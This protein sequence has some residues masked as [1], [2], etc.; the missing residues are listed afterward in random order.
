LIPLFNPRFSGQERF[1]AAIAG[2][3]D[4]DD[5]IDLLAIDRAPDSDFLGNMWRLL[6]EPGGLR[7]E[8]IGTNHRIAECPSAT[9]LCST[10]RYVVNAGL[11]IALDAYGMIATVDPTPDL[12]TCELLANHERCEPTSFTSRRLVSDPDPIVPHT[13]LAFDVGRDGSTEIVFAYASKT[14]L[15]SVLVCTTAFACDELVE[16][17]R[18]VDP[19]IVACVDAVPGTLARGSRDAGTVPDLVA[20]CRTASES[21]LFRID[22]LAASRVG[23]VAGPADAHTLLIDDVT[24]DAVDDIVLLRSTAEGPVVDV[25]RQRTLRQVGP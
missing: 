11:V 19:D 13:P 2:L 25:L 12:G 4:D 16:R 5:R 3:L 8:D 21:R 24:G 1:H 14:R 6:G 9:G 18:V 17:V 23:D 7:N 10:A 22:A 15:G 20:L